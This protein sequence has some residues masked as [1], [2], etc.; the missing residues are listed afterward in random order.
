VK[1]VIL[2]GGYGTRLAEE[3]EKIP[4]PLVPI[5]SYP[6]LQHIINSFYDQGFTEFHVAG[7]YK[8]ELIK[9]WFEKSLPDFPQ[10]MNVS[11]TNTGLDT[12]TG[13]RLKRLEESLMDDPFI[14]TYGDGLAD[15][16]FNMLLD[17]HIRMRAGVHPTHA[18]MVTLTAVNPPSRFGRLQIE[19]GLCEIFTEKGQDPDGWINSGFYVCQR[20]VLDMIPG[21]A[22]VWEKDILSQLAIQGRL[23][24]F[25]HN[26]EFQMMDT[27][28]DRKY[29]EDVW[30]Q[31]SPFWRRWSSDN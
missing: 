29:L 20:E 25:Q 22:C 18:T 26:G 7:G 5:G 6:I 9:A 8:W 19:H 10:G 30:A 21:D 16:N 17:H 28:R 24:A 14:L 27:W 15:I 31:G 2:A 1:V 23:A 4:K 11:V 12:C 13:G 3:T